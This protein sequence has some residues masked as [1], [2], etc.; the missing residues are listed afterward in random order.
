MKQSVW[1]PWTW[2]W[3]PL[4]CK[5]LHCKQFLILLILEAMNNN[6]TSVALLEPPC[7]PALAPAAPLTGLSPQ[8]SS[9]KGSGSKAQPC[10][11]CHREFTN[12]RHH[13]NQQHMQ[14]MSRDYL[15]RFMTM[16]FCSRLKILNARS[17][18][19]AATSRQTWRGTSIMSTTSIGARVQSAA[20]SIATLDNTSE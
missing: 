18:A 10:P 12:L 7:P 14:V 3:S 1:I 19:T 20:R 6:I 17:V 16:F 13:I 2:T 15:L 5:T 4:V 8:P 11:H 9:P